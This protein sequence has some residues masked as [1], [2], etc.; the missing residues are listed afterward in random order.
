MDHERLTRAIT[1]LSDLV[2]KL[3]SPDGCPWDAKQ[4]DDSI[5]MYL[6]EEAYEVLEAVEK[7]RSDDVCQELGD[8]LF[9]I[10]FMARLAEERGEYDLVDVMEGKATARFHGRQRPANCHD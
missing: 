5:K 4:T 6:L 7:G 10:L 8:L 2:P 9:Q 3:R 1:V